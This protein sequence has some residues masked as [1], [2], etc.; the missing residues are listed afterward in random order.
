[1]SSIVT[2]YGDLVDPAGEWKM[3]GLKSYIVE[4]QSIPGILYAV[5]GKAD[6]RYAPLRTGVPHEPKSILVMR[7]G[8]AGDILFLTPLLRRLRELYPDAKIDVAAFGRYE[9]VLDLNPHCN[10]VIRMP[11]CTDTV[12]GYDWTINLEGVVE[13]D[14]KHH[15]V[16]AFLNNAG[17]DDGDKTTV[18]VPLAPSSKIPAKG[19]KKRIGLQWEASSPIRCYPK[20]ME[21]AGAIL[22]E[23]HE[24]LI[25]A[26]PGRV[27]I[28]NSEKLPILNTGD[29]GL[30]WREAT[31][32]MQTCDVVVGPDS[33]AVH[34]AGAMNI[35]TVALYG[36][37]DW[38]LRTAYQ[39]SIRAI[40]GNGGCETCSFHGG[41][42]GPVPENKPCSS[43][44]KCVLLDNIEVK[45][46]MREMEH[47]LNVQ[48]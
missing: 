42:A 4:S 21:L 10:N 7:A 8:G 19:D 31:D 44:G 13:E 25:L 46:V 36:S 40:Q 12:M 16:D 27:K 26:E 2:L 24:L 23:G 3:E 33:S 14:T 45:R 32:A 1:M 22:R 37:F 5:N 9:W 18:Y 35:P 11:V 47:K 34:F 38:K 39:P 43:T 17:I 41:A 15:V 30:T 6:V 28:E 29:M 20:V 48:P